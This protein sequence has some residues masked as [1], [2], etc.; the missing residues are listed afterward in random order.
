[1]YFYLYTVDRKELLKFYEYYRE[2]L[3]K[4]HSAIQGRHEEL[5][6]KLFK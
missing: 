2:F 3:E 5:V 1:M 4:E 6:K